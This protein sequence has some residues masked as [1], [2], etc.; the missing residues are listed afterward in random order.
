MAFKFSVNYETIDP[1][2]RDA[3][4][5]DLIELIDQHRK[6]ADVSKIVLQWEEVHG[7]G[8]KRKITDSQEILPGVPIPDLSHFGQTPATPMERVW[9]KDESPQTTGGRVMEFL[10]SRETR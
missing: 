8:R 9:S 3:F 2:R 7:N 5:E 10:S 4:L 1:E 6:G